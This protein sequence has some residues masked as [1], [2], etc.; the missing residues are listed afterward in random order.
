MARESLPNALDACAA[1]LDLGFHIE[2]VIPDAGRA[3]VEDH[4][5]L[6]FRAEVEYLLEGV[7][8]R[9]EVCRGV[10]EPQQVEADPVLPVK[11]VSPAG[12]TQL[13][14]SFVEPPKR[15]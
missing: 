7:A 1:A 12:F 6:A 2:R 14:R 5:H 3:C 13:E 11:L 10:A 9:V 15:T 8:R 4:S